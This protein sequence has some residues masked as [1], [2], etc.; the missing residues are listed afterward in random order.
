MAA[1]ASPRSAIDTLDYLTIVV[2]QV[3]CTQ[4]MDLCRQHQI[5][6][7]PSIRVYRKGHDDVYIA[8]HH[9]HESYV[10]DRTKEALVKF[11]ET[12][13]PSAG[14]P[15][16]AHPETQKLTKHAG[17]NMA[18]TL[19]NQESTS[20]VFYSSRICPCQESPRDVAFPGEVPRDIF[21]SFLDEH[22]TLH[23]PSLLWHSSVSVQI[24]LLAQDASSGTYK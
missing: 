3:D 17:C 16:S 5:T 18:G 24:Q 22:D 4:D 15:H 21:R 19:R 12:L 8:H 13:V 14:L 9:M 20:T 10:G 2:C 7:F 6:G 1:S 11:A 23:P